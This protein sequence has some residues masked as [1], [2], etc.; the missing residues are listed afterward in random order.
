M[1]LARR[2]R[3]RPL[4]ALGLVLGT[5]MSARVAT[6]ESAVSLPLPNGAEQAA[7]LEL[8][9]RQPEGTSRKAETIPWPEAGKNAG[10]DMSWTPHSAAP[11]PH[12][13]QPVAAPA[14]RPLPPAPPLRATPPPLAPM[15]LRLA[16]GHQLLW[17]AAL[18]SLPLPEAVGAALSR[19]RDP[20]ARAPFYPAGREPA[21]RERRWSADGWLL[22]RRGDPIGLGGARAPAIYG[23]SQT[24]AVLRYRLAPGSGHRP[25][26]YAR[27]SAALDGS[28]QKEA[29]F[30]LS[31]RLLPNIP[32]IAAVELRTIGDTFGS[33]LSPVA[34]AI[35]ELPP[36]A[37][38]LGLRAEAYAQGGYAGGKGAT[39][40]A[41]GQMR[42]D[43]RI[44]SIGR[45]DVR[46]GGGAWGGAQE[47]IS[48]LDLGPTVTLGI[49][50]GGGSSARMAF[51]WRLRV[52][53]NAAPESGPALTLSAGF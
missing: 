5:W 30:G 26:A 48:R 20:Q 28:Q 45:V 13:P 50:V 44:G 17:M 41:D 27:A 8:A 43:H 10:L 21:L 18:S 2:R 38:P 15:P 22:L 11:L 7:R 23:A 9:G 53:G 29:A 14:I 39:A 52:A 40:F 34:M 24:G 1:S 4:V 51:D 46:A 35:T 37:L 25:A 49:P 42:L 36:I 31:A 16:A 47:G 6:W 32:V 12:A 33:R 19:D 3:G